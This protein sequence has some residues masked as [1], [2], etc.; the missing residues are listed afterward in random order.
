MHFSDQPNPT[1]RSTNLRKIKSFSFNQK[2]KTKT[3]N[4][5]GKAI[6]LVDYPNNKIKISNTRKVY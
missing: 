5:K 4:G 2:N 6:Y 3:G 1:F